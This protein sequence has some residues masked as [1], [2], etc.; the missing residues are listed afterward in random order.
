MHTKLVAIVGLP[1]VGKSTLFNRILG[2]RVAIVKDEPGVTRDR[3]IQ[4]CRKGDKAFLLSD[5]GGMDIQSKKGLERLVMDQVNQAVEEADILIHVFDGVKGLTP[6]DQEIHRFLRAK[7]KPIFCVVNKFDSKKTQEQIHEFYQLGEKNLFP[8]SSEHGQGVAELLDKILS[9]IE[10]E[11]VMEP[12]SIPKV[13]ILGRPNTGKSTMVNT[14]LKENRLVTSKI[15]GTTRDAIDTQ[16]NY[17]GKEYLFIDTAGIRKRSKVDRGIEYYSVNRAMKSLERSDLAILL[18]D[19]EE[20]ITDQDS[21]IANAIHDSGKGCILVLNKTDLV[22]DLNNNRRERIGFLKKQFPF[23]A[24]APIV[25]MSGKKGEGFSVLFERI[26][27]VMREYRKRVATSE[28][29]RVFEKM[30][31]HYPHPL[32]RGK[33]VKLLYITQVSICPPAF[34]VFLKRKLGMKQSYLRY[35]ENGIREAFSFEGTPIRIYL[36]EKI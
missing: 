3:N 15:P 11:P 24:H 4:L 7:N 5:T 25:F 28:L 29:N 14:L 23:L 33:E 27:R 36:R 34:V 16:V 31:K 20:G 35:L 9:D 10:P 12:S 32:Y 26:R 22:P 30:L 8:V 18:L 1:N 2:R 13:A 19:P 17:K 21:Q 6:L